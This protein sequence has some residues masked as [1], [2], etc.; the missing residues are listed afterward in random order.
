MGE[1]D[2]E[3]LKDVLAETLEVPPSEREERLRELCGADGALFAA[4]AELLRADRGPIRDFTP[5]SRPSKT[6]F[7]ALRY[8]VND[9]RYFHTL[10][11]RGPLY[12]GRTER[13]AEPSLALPVQSVSRSQF[14]LETRDGSWWIRNLS[15]TNPTRLNGIRLEA[16]TRL[17]HGARIRV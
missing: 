13:P 16:P 4:A 15:G 14:V 6:L 7:P 11:A 2:R 17:D 1:V 12:V 3:R 5:E 9:D 8:E 10:P